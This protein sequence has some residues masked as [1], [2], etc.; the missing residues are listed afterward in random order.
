M[1]IPI[2]VH[3]PK[4]L[5]EHIFASH[6]AIVGPKILAGALK[7]RVDKEAEDI[8]NENSMLPVVSLKS[9]IESRR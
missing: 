3:W 4:G 1:Q 9:M 8:A 5:S 6:T 7:Q 2:S